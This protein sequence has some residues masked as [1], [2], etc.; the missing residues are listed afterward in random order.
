MSTWFGGKL[1]PSRIKEPPSQWCTV[2]D[3][4]CLE[5]CMISFSL[6]ID[7]QQLHKT[8]G[9]ETRNLRLFFCSSFR[10]RSSLDLHSSINACKTKNIYK[11]DDKFRVSSLSIGCTQPL[12]KQT[13]LKF[14]FEWHLV[15]LWISA[16]PPFIRFMFAWAITFKFFY[17][18]HNLGHRVLF[19]STVIFVMSIIVY[20]W[21][22]F[23]LINGKKPFAWIYWIGNSSILLY[24]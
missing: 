7:C 15:G 4:P 14:L 17:L 5:I 1:L 16:S 6:N 20:I 3:V 23:C 19:S 18:C 22:K 12:E 13:Y 10:V 2:Y 11:K 24:I 9:L 8:P 21:K